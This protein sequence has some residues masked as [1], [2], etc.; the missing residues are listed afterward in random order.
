MRPGGEGG[1]LWTGQGGR[2]RRSRR[3]LC[4]RTRPAPRPSSATPRYLYLAH[5]R[6]ASSVPF[7]LPRHGSCLADARFASI[8]SPRACRERSMGMATLVMNGCWRSATR[9][10]SPTPFL[11]PPPPASRCVRYHFNQKLPDRATVPNAVRLCCAYGRDGFVSVFF[12]SCVVS[13]KW[14][15]FG[16]LPANAVCPGCCQADDAHE[17][18]ECCSV[19]SSDELRHISM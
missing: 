11:P 6:R 18:S 8:R 16:R 9:P 3:R 13:L 4:S 7:L 15:C 19:S 5:V 2:A 1:G 10:T 17:T 14:N 12:Y